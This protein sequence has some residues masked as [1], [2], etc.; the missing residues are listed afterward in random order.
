MLGI[1]MKHERR[2][3]L[4]I[5]GAISLSLFSFKSLWGKNN[6]LSNK[7][8]IGKYREQNENASKQINNMDVGKIIR[9][10]R[11]IAPLVSEVIQSAKIQ[12]LRGKLTKLELQTHIV[13]K[14]VDY[15]L[16]PSMAGY[17][18]FP[19]AVAISIDNELIHNVPDNTAVPP[20]SLVTIEVGASSNMA[21]ASQAWSFLNPP[22]ASNKQN[23][24]RVATSALLE[25]LGQVKDGSHVGNIGNKIQTTIEEGGFN[26][27]REYCGYAMGTE[28]MLDPQILGYGKLE[29]GPLMRTGQILNIHVLA[30]EGKRSVVIKSDGWGVKSKD[31][32]NSVALSAMALVKEDSY[33][34]LSAINI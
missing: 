11:R 12:V 28:R 2:N 6:I 26:V 15:N 4:A 32:S 23:L 17:H 5:L 18:G 22:I 14:L 16:I 27:V 31:G 7:Y 33:E 3:C 10:S 24:I 19:G 34:L 8:L 21:F 13:N 25:A 20:G 9:E 30:N 1:L 29:T